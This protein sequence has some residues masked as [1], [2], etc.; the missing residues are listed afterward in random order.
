MKRQSFEEQ[1]KALKT[2]I[3]AQVNQIKIMR[4][5]I[6]FHK[7]VIYDDLC[8]D[9][10]SCACGICARTRAT[11]KSMGLKRDKE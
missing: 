4:D 10:D 8:P 7:N 5:V 1:N 9:D 3:K 6:K 11:L 2:T